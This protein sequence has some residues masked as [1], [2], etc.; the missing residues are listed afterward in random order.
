MQA[1]RRMVLPIYALV[2]VN[3]V[4]FVDLFVRNA[5]PPAE[6]PIGIATGA[7]GGP[8][9]LWLLIRSSRLFYSSVTS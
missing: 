6:I 8:F 4:L 3:I 1:S 9:F 7:L 5:I 2:G